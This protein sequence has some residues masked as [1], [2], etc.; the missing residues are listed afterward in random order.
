MAKHSINRTYF[1]AKNHIRLVWKKTNIWKHRSNN[2]SFEMATIIQWTTLAM[3]Y[4][5][6]SSNCYCQNYTRMI[7]SCGS[8]SSM[9]GKKAEKKTVTKKGEWERERELGKKICHPK[10]PEMV[11]TTTFHPKS[12]QSGQIVHTKNKI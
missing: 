8:A 2:S 12:L 6:K 11:V 5:S 10:C 7:C 3:E 9:I 1:P 4:G